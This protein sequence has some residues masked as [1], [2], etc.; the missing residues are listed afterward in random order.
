MRIE[1]ENL[2][3]KCIIGVLD[4]ER[5]NEQRVTVNAI[6]DYSY[7]ENSYLDYAE[8]CNL[9]KTNLKNKKFKLLEDAL[10]DTKEQIFNKFKPV[11]SLYLKISKPDI[12]KDCTVSLS[13]KWENSYQ[14][15]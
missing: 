7:T 15:S 14:L 13:G 10:L 2:T 9:I 8:V 5:T 1:I 12:L 6:I 3:F 4:F 11:K